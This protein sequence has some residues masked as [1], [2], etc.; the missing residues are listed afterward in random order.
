M[1][2]GG[3]DVGARPPACQ[4]CAEKAEI[5]MPVGGAERGFGE[6]GDR[7]TQPG[8]EASAR[9][10]ATVSM[11][12]A[13]ARARNRQTHRQSGRGRCPDPTGPV[14]RTAH[15]V[16][17]S[18]P[19]GSSV[20]K[21]AR[22]P[23]CSATRTRPSLQLRTAAGRSHRDWPEDTARYSSHI[24]EARR[25]K[26]SSAARSWRREPMRDA[27]AAAFAGLRRDPAAAQ[28]PAVLRLP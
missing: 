21:P 6:S 3:G 10:L 15:P 23:S 7:K 17:R 4:D 25:C 20:A 1:A 5:R 18:R 16:R 19:C 24:S 26:S 27:H 11:A 8:I 2:T 28:H 12:A 14:P 22:P 13:P 9:G